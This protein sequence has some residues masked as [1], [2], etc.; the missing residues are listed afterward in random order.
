MR[1]GILRMSLR[2]IAIIAIIGAVAG[3]QD[4]A[5]QACCPTY[6]SVARMTVPA[7]CFPLTITTIWSG[8]FTGTAVHPGVGTIA[9]AAPTPPGC[10]PP[11][12]TAIMVNGVA[13]PVPPVGGCT[14]VA[15]PCGA[16]Q[17]CIRLNPMGCVRVVVE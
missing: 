8:A 12:I 17:V 1:R 7:G 5:A 14:P 13:V 3:V 16:V 15:L 9:I 6:A 2:A 11:P 4:A 10:W